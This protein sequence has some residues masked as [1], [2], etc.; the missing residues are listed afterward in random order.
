MNDA[1]PEY[2]LVQALRQR[3]GA[4]LAAVFDIY[5]DRV[6]RLALSLLHDPQAAEDVVQ[7]VFLALIE[8]IESFEGRASLGTWLYRVAYNEAVGRLRRSQVHFELELDEADKETAMPLIFFDWQSLPEAWLSSAEVQTQIA[9]AVQALNPTMRAVFMLRDIEELSTEETA[10]ILGI[11]PGAVKVRL[12]RA[13]LVLR[14]T[15]AGYFQEEYHTGVGRPS[16][17][18]R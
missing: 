14:E 17:T 1:S 10:E 3:D 18:P 7:E 2:E 12:H 11:S 9:N 8:H 4:A 15:L 6:Y 5:S 16:T 13:R